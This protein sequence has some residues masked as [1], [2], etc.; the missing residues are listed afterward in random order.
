MGSGF[1]GPP[2]YWSLV[3]G[4]LD[5]EAG[6]GLLNFLILG[7][8]RDFR[9]PPKPPTGGP[10]AFPGQGPPRAKGRG[11]AHPAGPLPRARPRA[12][13]PAK[14]R[15]RA[16][17]AQGFQ[18]RARPRVFSF[19]LSSQGFWGQRAG[20]GP[21]GQG[22]PRRRQE[23]PKGFKSFKRPTKGRGTKICPCPQ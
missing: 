17:R 7:A 3:A 2:G 20:Q 6:E 8:F 21:P 9:G 14:G 12:K 11:P 16:P 5:Q 23:P 4:F 19:W 22:K 15:L 1:V 18:S 13:T 10:R